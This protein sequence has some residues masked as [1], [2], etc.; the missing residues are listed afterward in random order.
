MGATNGA[1]R[2]L[3]SHN[4]AKN[5]PPKP[6]SRDRTCQSRALRSLNTDQPLFR[7]TGRA[8]LLFSTNQRYPPDLPKSLVHAEHEIL[9][10]LYF[11]SP[12]LS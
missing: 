9:I 2:H 7:P 5:L 4:L 12:S 1:A 11:Q 6:K 8:E 3:A 10:F